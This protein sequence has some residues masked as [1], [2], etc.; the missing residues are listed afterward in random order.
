VTKFTGVLAE[1]KK[2]LQNGRLLSSKKSWN[3]EDQKKGMGEFE[4][5]DKDTIWEVKKG[6]RKK[7]EK[8]V[9]PPS[10]GRR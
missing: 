10:M 2:K 3:R 5:N 8:D 6:Y 9:L 1:R 7:K 4:R